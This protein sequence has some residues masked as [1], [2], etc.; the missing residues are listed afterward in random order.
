MVGSRCRSY[1]YKITTVAQLTKINM[2]GYQATNKDISHPANSDYRFRLPRPAL[3]LS[4]SSAYSGC[5]EPASPIYG[6]GERI[7]TSDHLNPIQVR[8]LAALHPDLLSNI[9]A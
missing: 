1:P 3:V 9:L 4:I 8:Y 7:R 5:L 6:R 2:E